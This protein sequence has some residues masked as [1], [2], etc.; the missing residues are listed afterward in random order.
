MSKRDDLLQRRAT[1]S[2]TKRALLEQWSQGTSARPAAIPRRPVDSQPPLSF[3]QQRLWVIDQ[4]IPNSPAYNISTSVRL[5]GRLMVDALQQSLDALVARH[6]SLRT[7][8]PLSGGRPIQQV[9]PALTIPL[10][11]ID[12]RGEPASARAALAL[13]HASAEVQRAFDLARGPLLRA[14]LVRLDDDQ[15]MLVLVVHHIVSDGWSVGIMVRELATLYSG[16]ADGRP[17]SLPALPIQYA[18]FAIWQ[19]AW[20]QGDALEKQLRFWRTHLDGAPLVLELPTDHPRPPVQSFRGDA[21]G[22][23][24]APALADALRAL[25]RHE[26]VTLFMTLLAAYQT[27]MYRYSRQSDI[28]VGTPIANRTRVETEGLIGF[29]V[30]TLVV[31]THLSDTLTFRELVQRVR[32]STLEAHAHQDLPFEQLVDVLQ[33]TRDM[34][35]NPLFQIMFVLQN[36][37]PSTITTPGLTLEVVPVKSATSKFDLWLSMEEYGDSIL[38]IMECNTDLFDPSTMRRIMR[39]F[40]RLLDSVVANPNQPLADLPILTRAE[41]QQLLCEWNDTITAGRRLRAGGSGIAGVCIHE[42]F[43]AQAA[44]TPDAVALVFDETNDERPRTNGASASFVLHLTYAELNQRAN[45]LA[46]YLQTLGVGPDVRVGMCVDRSLD[47]VIGLFGILKAGGAYVPIDPVSPPER[48]AFMINDAQALVLLVATTDDGPRT[49][50]DGDVRPVIVRRSSFVGKLVDL[51]ADWPA[52]EQARGLPR[53][54]AVAP[55]NLGYVIY[56]SGSTGKPKGVAM[57]HR[58]LVN[59]LAWQLPYLGHQLGTR[60][61]QFASLSFDVSYQEIF[62]TLASGGTVALISEALRRDLR[63]LWLFLDRADIDRVYLP[64]V[65]LRQ[66]AETADLH[67]AVPRHLRQVTVSGEQLQ[68]TG[69]I[70]RMFQALGGST[71]NNFYGP[72]ESHAVTAHSLRGDPTTWPTLVPI[73]RPIANTQM[74][75]VDQQMR[76]PPIGIPGELLIGGDCLAYGYLNRPDLTAERFVPNPFG[77]CRLQIADCRVDQST[78]DYRLSAIGYRLYR[79]GDLARYRADGSL[80]FLGRIDQQVKLRGY[81]VE[82][83]EIEAVLTQ[84]PAVRECVVLAR[85]DVSPTSG[86]ADKRLVA[87]LVPQGDAAPTTSELRSFIQAQLPEYMVPSLFMPLKALPLTL[88]RKID[89]NALPA[90][91]ATRPNLAK[92]FVAPRTAIERTL[93]ALWS[94]IIGVEQIGIYDN[95]FELGGDSIRSIQIVIQANKAGLRLSPKLLF[96]HQTIAELASVAELDDTRQAEQSAA[97]GPVPLT[98]IQRWFFEQRYPAP[99]RW[100]RAALLDAPPTLSPAQLATT[101]RQLLTHHD[102]L[103]LRFEQAADGPRACIDVLAATPLRWLD[104]SALPAA[105]QRAAEQQAISGMQAELDLGRSPLVRAALLDHGAGQPRRV[106]LV[107]HQLVADQAA[108]RIVLADLT[109]AYAQLARGEPI[110]LP[111]AT[112]FKRWAEW[113]L[114]YA[115][116]SGARQE[117]DYWRAALSAPSARLPLA[118]PTTTGA[119]AARTVSRVLGVAETHALLAD[120]PRA[121]RTRTAEVLLTAL[122]QTLADWT[123]APALLLDLEEQGRAQ[124]FDGLDLART[125]GWLSYRYPVRLDLAEIAGPGAALTAIKEQLRAVPNQGVGYSALRYLG[126]DAT[127]AQL[128]SLPQAEISFAYA[129]ADATWLQTPGPLGLATAPVAPTGQRGAHAYPLAITAHIADERLQ[130]DWTY[131]TAQPDATISELAER[132]IAA[133]RS[134]IAHCQSP[135]AGGYTPSDFP[136][137]GLTQPQLDRI[138][139]ARGPIADIY[140]LGPLQ[141]HMLEQRLNH[142]ES[143]LYLASGVYEVPFAVDSAS[144]ERA[145]QQVIDRHPVLRTSFVWEGLDQPLQIV[146]E[147]ARLTMTHADLR[148]LTPAE[149]QARVAEYFQAVRRTS[150]ALTSAPHTDVALFRV[151]DERYR[152][153]WTFDYMLQDGW[154]FLLIHDFLACYQAA[155]SGQRPQLDQPR[156]Y[157]D[158]IAWTRQQDMAG[159]EAFW[160][161]MLRGF[162]RPTPLKACTPGNAPVEG[163]YMAQSVLLPAT[164]TAAVQELARQHQLTPYT[165]LQAAWASLLSSYTGAQ[166]VVYGVVVSGRPPELAGVEQMVGLFN[167]LLP[168]RLRVEPAQPLLPWLKGIQDQLTDLRQYEYSPPLMVKQWSD[169]PA[170]QPLFESYMVYENLPVSESVVQYA[171]SRQIRAGDSLSQTEH[172]LRFVIFPGPQIMLNISFYPHHFD[173]PTIRRILADFQ[174]M[175]ERIVESLMSLDR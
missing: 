116:S 107:L 159:A 88:N 48:L 138:F 20:L 118:A 26:E 36:T 51:R 25:C 156:P 80:E 171:G 99:Q 84:H 143:G 28:L 149:Q 140:P 16:F 23:R 40:Q 27:L 122:A 13:Q 110:M 59:L 115:R 164:L 82:L 77:D 134:L 135:D 70:I 121:Y 136:L 46:Q 3:A 74:Y 173:P 152:F 86:Y 68:I 125:V 37:P 87:Y 43:E 109:S 5:S 29:F 21:A 124:S 129:E 69:P 146:H 145:W 60:F 81:R 91:D 94:Q 132:S 154:G 153:V 35:R 139:A 123:G 62:P 166:D 30:N 158:Y 61:L 63:N 133:L 83:E 169:V 24:L 58:A 128:R 117:L 57:S 85:A 167:N 92:E 8:F 53:R 137:A 7:T 75:V 14:T 39:H 100:S 106:A 155:C 170:D 105:Q 32:E 142:A 150:F 1:L 162:A 90:P 56:T 64:Y 47:L 98:P 9:A 160:R 161:A 172:P 38:G 104:L 4:L 44:R 144:F 101:V 89:R 97:S 112:S 114:D 165:L 79:T 52:I 18:D 49:K 67:A 120:V 113:L 55:D 66:L 119:T 17:V 33:P 126:D 54:G 73:G 108:W 157:R 34:S 50:D 71:L 131:D 12:L 96:Q 22:F 2:S 163:P 6:E 148:T 127:R 103:R 151:G 175:L 11:L 10:P 42:L 41:R 72:S 15:H 147:H 95:F 130:L 78:N 111:A 65:G 93:A 31:R 168:M 174:A 102:A 141:A 19:R 76:P 45:Q